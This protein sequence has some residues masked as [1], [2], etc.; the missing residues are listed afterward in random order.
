MA[1]H[2]S[3]CSAACLVRCGS[4]MR[5]KPS[6]GRCALHFVNPPRSLPVLGRRPTAQDDNTSA[7]DTA[8]VYPMLLAWLEC[9][10]GCCPAGLLQLT[11]AALQENMYHSSSVS[12]CRA[13]SAS[14]AETTCRLCVDPCQYPE[15]VPESSLGDFKP[16]T[17]LIP[18]VPAYISA[19][20]DSSAMALGID[21][22]YLVAHLPE[23]L[24]SS[25]SGSPNTA[26]NLTPNKHP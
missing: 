18:R 15:V 8:P 22:R 26:P 13:L 11:L 16:P 10:R 2:G 17:S 20:A 4:N 19:A 7:L 23:I 12:M 25:T 6:P 21:D 24:N 9:Q 14:Q 3:G 1:T 5:W